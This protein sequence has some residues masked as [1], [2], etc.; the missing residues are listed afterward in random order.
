M[1]YNFPFNT[2]NYD[3]SNKTKNLTL[4]NYILKFV[5]TKERKKNERNIV[6]T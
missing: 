3:L 6:S 1:L 2:D 4:N 5:L